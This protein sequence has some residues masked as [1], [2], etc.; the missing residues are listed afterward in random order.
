M[1]RFR[2][3]CI[4]SFLFLIAFGNLSY[5]QAKENILE[6]STIYFLNG[7]QIKKEE[8]DKFRQSLKEIED[9][10]HCKLTKFG[11]TTTYEGKDGQGNRYSVRSEDSS[12]ISKSSIEIIKP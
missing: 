2:T 10:Y 9:T 4:L 6:K 5:S 7:T 12:K 8:Y 3:I 11:G 1:K